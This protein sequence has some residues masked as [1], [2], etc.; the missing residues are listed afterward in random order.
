MVLQHKL[1]TVWGLHK[2]RLVPP[3][4]PRWLWKGHTFHVEP[5][6]GC[7]YCVTCS[8]DRWRWIVVRSVAG[9]LCTATESSRIWF[10]CDEMSATTLCTCSATSRA[11]WSRPALCWHNS[12]AALCNVPASCRRLSSSASDT[13]ENT[14][15]YTARLHHGKI[16]KPRLTRHMSVTKEYKSQARGHE[17]VYG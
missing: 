1:V 17:I 11:F 12:T 13:T 5:S 16:I 10:S 8:S 6:G 2:Q 4:G 9:L 3:W 15:Q 14:A 7:V